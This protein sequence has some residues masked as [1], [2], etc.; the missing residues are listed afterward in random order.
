MTIANTD[1]NPRGRQV[2]RLNI[3]TIFEPKQVDENPKRQRTNSGRSVSPA[4]PT[5]T[6]KQDKVIR[7]TGAVRE[8][9]LR[10][11]KTAPSDVF[12]YGVHPSTSKQDII[13]DLKFSGVN[14]THGAPIS[15][16]FATVIYKI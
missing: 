15:V 13:D 5:Q 4:P 7:G 14:I 11:M 9:G 6:R 10:K 2:N 12:V 1:L 3:P 8:E 16:F